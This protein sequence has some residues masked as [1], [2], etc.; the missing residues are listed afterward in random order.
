MLD[1]FSL[2][3]KVAIVTGASRGIGQAIAVGLARAGADLVITSRG[4]LEETERKIVEAGR[5]CLKVNVDLF[6][7][8]R[9]KD[10]IIGETMKTFGRLDI[11]VNNAGIQRR[12]PVLEFTEKDW[13]EVI[14]INLKAVFILSQAAAAIMKENGWGK[15]INLASM[16]SFQ[17]GYTVPAYA[18]S[19]GGVAQL[20]KA[21]AN[22][23]ARYGINVNAIAPGYIDTEMNKALIQDQERN[24]QILERIPAGRWGKPEDLVGAAIFLASHASDYVNGHILCVDGGWLAR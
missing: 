6:D 8:S 18:A 12:N 9:A 14:Q 10:L 16:L 24:R 13:D 1:L 21:F 3:G 19:K 4:G 23:L 2:H 5:K 17:G 22:E 11:L 7:L 15:I 20:T